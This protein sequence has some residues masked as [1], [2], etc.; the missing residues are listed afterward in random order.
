MKLKHLLL[1]AIPVV[2]SACA[3]K[4]DLSDNNSYGL[5]CSAGPN[6]TPDWPL[7]Q[8][9]ADRVCAPLKAGSIVQHNPTGSGSADDAYFISF[10]CE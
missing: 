8:A 9:N 6:A 5:K 7:C 2:L 1:I 4:I 3:S 10:K